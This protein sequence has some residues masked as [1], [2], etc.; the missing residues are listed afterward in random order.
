MPRK[1]AGIFF[2][3]MFFIILGCQSTAAA[4]GIPSTAVPR[5]RIS[6]PGI[7]AHGIFDPSITLD[8]EDGRLWMSYSAVDGSASWPEQNRDVVSIRLAYSSDEGRTWTDGGMVVSNFLDVTLPL[9]PP[10][11]AGT[12]VSEVSTLVYDPGA[13]PGERWKLLW[14][15]YLI[16]NNSRRFEHG[17]VALKTAPN[18]EALAAA[19]EVKLFAGYLYDPGNDTAGGGSR[20]PVGDP[21]RIQLDTAL[22]PALNTCVFT[23]P[24]MYATEDALYASLLCKHLA[25]SDSRI[26]LLK[27][28]SPCDAERSGAW[29]YLG[30]A[31]RESDAAESGFD[32][33]FSAPSMFASAGNIFLVATPVKTSGAPWSNYYSGC[34]VFRFS[35]FETAR[36]ERDG[37]RLRLI[38]EVNGS[39]GSFNG[40]CAFHPAAGASGLLFSELVPSAVDKFRIFM[41]HILF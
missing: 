34:R 32:E 20:A 1:P 8:P 15:H 24:G 29:T 27:C 23:E 14:H 2:L 39:A 35:D 7:G 3:L 25:D 10:N 40:A 12:W 41:S 36:L 4:G 5:D 9:K 38:G 19:P 33:G 11:D 37:T 16:V 6:F 22:D 18:P 28:A 30:T 21:P 31:L 13:I 26:V 17:W